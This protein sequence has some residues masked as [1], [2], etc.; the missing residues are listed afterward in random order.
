MDPST[1][2]DVAAL[3]VLSFNAIR[4]TGDGGWRFPGRGLRGLDSLCGLLLLGDC[5]DELRV[6]CQL[7]DGYQRC[8]VVSLELGPAQDRPD[9]VLQSP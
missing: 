7:R 8:F 3:M 2:Y 4:K 6:R 1:Q 9:R 5:S